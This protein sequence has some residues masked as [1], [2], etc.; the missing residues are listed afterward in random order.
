MDRPFRAFI[1]R[2]RVTIQDVA[3]ATGIVLLIGFGAYHYFAADSA[4][5]GQRIE[6][7][8][9]L[10][11]GGLILIPVV[12]LGWRRVKDL[13]HEINRRMAAERRA[14]ELTHTDPLTGL[15]NRHQFELT[16]RSVAAIPCAPNEAHGLLMLD[17]KNFRKINELYG[18]AE[19]D[20]LLVAVAERLR[21]ITRER[22]FLAHI[23]A[24]EFALIAC[25]LAGPEGA[26]SI[27]ARIMRAMDV[28]IH[29][30]SRKHEMQIAV[31]IALI[32]RDGIG[33]EEIMRKADIALTRAKGEPES[34]SR[35]FE[36]EL[37]RLLR[38]RDAIAR[39][40]AFAIGTDDVQ[41][42]FQPIVDLATGRV[43]ALE[44][45]AR[46]HAPAFGPI[47]PDRF[48][49]IAEAFGLIRSLGDW[50]LRSAVKEACNWPNDVALSFNI[51][52][53]QLQDRTLG[54]R[55]LSIL[56][57]FGLPPQRLMIE[58]TESAFV[59]DI[60]AAQDILASLRDAGIRIAVDDFGTGYFSLY[61]LRKFKL[62]VLKIDRSFIHAMESE[63]ES[64]AIVKAIVG[65]G[66]GLDLTV[67]AEG[68]ETA[69]QRDTLAAQDCQ[70]GQGFLFGE[71][72]PA[73][74][75]RAFFAPGWSGPS[76]AI[77]T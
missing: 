65:L 25:H 57:E 76:A 24:D 49:P 20:D 17:L 26:S 59:R 18:H 28:P 54:L 58:L 71:A 70:L 40:L 44:A 63:P 6:I 64:L 42:W 48:I 30:G 56:G 15:G 8:D 34:A 51:S 4:A 35:F 7:R 13:E 45:L 77:R 60:E 32:P 72:V 11:V 74:A 75:A 5:D 29:I 69:S 27:A 66:K 62:D 33:A 22:D 36:D 31:G 38:E 9:V 47:G 41:P 61:H 39:E 43:V 2:H 21:A 3:L 10:V 19:G 37:D 1:R 68:I 50:L 55:I 67:I 52:P 53:V 73:E 23:G 16:L 14:H 46:W 12:Y